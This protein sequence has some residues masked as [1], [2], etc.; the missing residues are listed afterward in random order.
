M[1]V[2]KDS[3]Q[4]HPVRRASFKGEVHRISDE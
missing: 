1:S 2:Q 4:N 3:N